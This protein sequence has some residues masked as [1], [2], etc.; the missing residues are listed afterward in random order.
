MLDQQVGGPHD[1]L[2]A[3]ARAWIDGDPDPTT[4]AQLQALLD[5][6]DIEAI[7][8]HVDG[9]LSFGTAGIR[10][11]VGP[12]PRRMNR[13]IALR[14]AHGL[15]QHVLATQ[16]LPAAGPA[17]VG[18]DARTSS[19]VLAADLVA[20][21]A[22]AG[23]PVEVL[24]RMAPTPL[25]A[26]RAV[27]ND[28]VTAVVVTASHNPARDNGIKVYARNH[29][30]LVEPEDLQIAARIDAAP[31]AVAID[32]RTVADPPN[33]RVVE[34]D[35]LAQKYRRDI[36]AGR[37][38]EERDTSLRIVATPLHGVGGEHLVAL[39]GAAGYADVRLVPEQAAPDGTF[40]TVAFPNPEE[41]GALDLALALAREVDADLVLANDPDADRL[42]MAIPDGRGGFQP[43]S[44]N[45]VGGLFGARLLATTGHARP[46]VAS[47][48]VS[49]PLLA[50]LATAHGAVHAVTLTGFKWIWNALL[51]LADD[52]AAPIYGFE[53]A[54]GYSVSP[55]VRDK[56]GLSAGLLAADIAAAARR[57]GR[58]VRDLLDDLA[59]Q[60]GARASVQRSIR[61]PGSEG[62]GAI[63]AALARLRSDPPR[64]LAGIPVRNVTDYA[65]GAD[66]RPR[67]LGAQDLLVFD[68]GAD[69]V[70]LRP[71]GTEP[72]LKVY[73]HA[74]GPSGPSGPSGAD[75]SVTEDALRARAEGLA[76]ALIDVA[77]L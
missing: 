70:L 7:A 56:D 15:A 8:D 9:A 1:Q 20:V 4:R 21:L 6:G 64:S 77:G 33:R 32:A 30:Q 35:D 57:A 16:D 28:A 72:K 3:A 12:G 66:Q 39:L 67:W 14:T 22:A 11:E 26:H 37:H 43:L 17:V 44:G 40:P 54:L 74:S 18:H 10:G 53:E 73:A 36:L 19:P 60:H 51:D 68:V 61:L 49:A 52:G 27:S 62:A 76:A 41:P 23:I 46:A 25:V 47:S 31:S 63:A 42:A 59:R 75:V 13:A 71:S 65:H 69:L 38:D 29:V 34:V 48:I 45:Q 2:R 5:D 50:D 24:D 58:T 55:V